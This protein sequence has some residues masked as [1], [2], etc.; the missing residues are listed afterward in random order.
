M[1]LIKCPECGKEISD[2]APA[3][4]QCGFPLI[5]QDEK[6]IEKVEIPNIDM[7]IGN[8]QSSCNSFMRNPKLYDEDF[9]EVFP[10][11][12]AQI[13]DIRALIVSCSKEQLQ[14]VEDRIA[15]TILDITTRASFFCSWET[16]KIYYELVKFDKITE[17]AM[18]KIADKLYE[19]ISIVEHYNDGSSGNNEHIMK[20]YPIYQVLTHGS[21]CIKKPILSILNQEDSSDET[22]Y[23]ELQDMINDHLGDNTEMVILENVP[24]CPTCGS[25]NIYKISGISK[26]GS[27]AMWGLFSRK[28]HKQWHCKNCRSEW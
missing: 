5:K 2:Q 22:R 4:I 3:C 18:K 23:E 20:W 21:E 17:D 11:I 14:A 6:Q 27:V 12:K 9:A 16:H 1:S 25:T 15:I 19:E 26:A 7:Q 13:K 28:V 10:G 24:K 8:I